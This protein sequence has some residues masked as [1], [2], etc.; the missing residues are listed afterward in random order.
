MKV[1][2]LTNS[3]LNSIIKKV[4]KEQE[5]QYMATGADSE[6]MSEALMKNQKKPENRIM[7]NLLDL[8]KI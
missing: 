1:V 4:L 8:H 7:A 6:K 3:K 5:D 2:K